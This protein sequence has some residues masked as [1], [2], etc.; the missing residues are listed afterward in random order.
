MNRSKIS[1]IHYSARTRLSSGSS[2]EKSG[3]SF[4]KNQE[5]SSLEKLQIACDCPIVPTNNAN[6]VALRKSTA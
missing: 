3:S 1:K 4:R 2:H 6:R 5:F